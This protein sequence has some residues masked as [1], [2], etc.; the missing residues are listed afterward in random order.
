M[1]TS[2][3][4]VKRELDL[5]LF[6]KAY[7][8]YIMKEELD[9]A[10]ALVESRIEGSKSRKDQY[11]VDFYNKYKDKVYA[12]LKQQRMFYQELLEK[13]KRFEKAY[14]EIT[15]SGTLESYQKAERMIQ[16][17]LKYANEN[18]FKE[19]A[20]YLKTYLLYNEAVIYDVHSTYDLV[21]LTNRSKHFEEFFNPLV[22]SDSISSI[23]KAEDLLENCLNYSKLAR[24][25]LDSTYF[26]QQSYVIATALSDLLNRAGREKELDNYTNQ[27][28]KARLDTLNPSGVF[29]WNDYIVVID[30]FIPG[31]SFENVKKGEAIIHADNMLSAYLIKNE[32]C[33]S[34]GDLKFGYVY[35]I[36]YISNIRN[37]AFYYNT[38]T[39]KW[40]YI[41]CYTIINSETYTRDVS[42]FM[43]PIYFDENQDIVQNN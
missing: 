40:Q 29:K 27:A 28:L 19:T 14:A 31:S 12:Q 18:D 4:S 15:K 21:K 30:E 8:E 38:D 36:P 9:K 24:T 5:T 32:L 41:A 42:K 6:V 25:A 22:E 26:I 34:A 35:I 33:K 3:Y 37:S 2:Y 11:S 39:R 16:L 20:A 7:E 13:E 17:A 43:P 1:N 23:M 10:R